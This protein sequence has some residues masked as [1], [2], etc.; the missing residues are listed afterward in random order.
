M[1]N[2]GIESSSFRDPCGFVFYQGGII[3]R[4]I[5][6]SYQGAYDLLMESGLYKALADAG[7]IV[8]HTEAAIEPPHKE[9]AYKVISPE[10]VPFVSYPYEWC[11][12]QLKDAAL[13]TLDIQK[14]ALEYGMALKD[15]TAYNI[16]FFG[17]RPVLIDTLSFEPYTQGEP[18][19]AYRQFCQHFLAP[20]ALM[21]HRDV[22]L[23]QMLKLYLDGIPLDLAARLLPRN[24]K[25]K[26]SLLTHIHLHAKSQT[27][28]A[29]KGVEKKPGGM[30]KHAYMGLIDSLESAIR[31]LR[32]QPRDTEWADYYDQTNYTEQSFA[33]KQKLVQNF[34]DRASPVT[35]WD[36]GANDGSFSRLALEKNA[37]VIA[38]DIDPAAVE[39]CYR[40]VVSNKD[41][42][43][44]PLLMD[45][46]NPSPAIG[47]ENR[48][49]MPLPARG[50]PDLALMLALI[51]HL[52]IGA[53]VPLGR[54]AQ[55]A[56]GLCNFLVIEFVP[57]SDSQVQRMLSFREDVF[58]DYSKE[59]FEAEFQNHFRILETARVGDSQRDLYLMQLREPTEAA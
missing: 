55:F 11:F 39:K 44:L 28:Y 4:Q 45:F 32:W 12:G 27:R 30:S 23:N 47:W 13:A 18:W 8:S 51:H 7:K 26:F 6:K 40:E 20:L 49:R 41:D 19:V 52:A 56:A 34:L 25:W 54:I 10:P 59:A 31:K 50:H 35:V 33:D 43:L 53:N 22:R 48:E 38:F 36:L 5:N 42:R 9:P 21:A 1:R 24:T 3:Y 29:D 17:Y 2:D 16:Q 14:T 15:A 57:K 58:P 37:E 46:T